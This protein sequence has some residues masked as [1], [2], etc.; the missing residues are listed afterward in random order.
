[1]ERSLHEKE[2]EIS[3]E[4]MEIDEQAS[5]AQKSLQKVR[6]SQA[7]DNQD[8]SILVE[9]LQSQQESLSNCRKLLDE[10]RAQAHQLRTGQRITKAEMNDGGKLLV[11]L[12]NY[13]HIDGQIRQEIHDIKATNHGKGVVGIVNGFDVNAFFND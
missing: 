13:D 2:I 11:G 4:M 7:L 12:I 6:E 3:E 5:V 1:M 9:Q 8:H 10:L